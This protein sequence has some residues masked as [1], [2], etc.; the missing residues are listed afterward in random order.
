MATSL[1][2]Q[3]KGAWEKPAVL[4]ATQAK[5]VAALREGRL[6]SRPLPLSSEMPRDSAGRMTY[7]Q[8]LPPLPIP[9]VSAGGEG[10]TYH[11]EAVEFLPISEEDAQRGQLAAAKMGNLVALPTVRVSERDSLMRYRLPIE[12]A[13]PALGIIGIAHAMGNPFPCDAEFGRVP[14]RSKFGGYYIELL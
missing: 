12:M 4:A 1:E 13:E 9:E 8:A 5:M 7:W 11:V 6:I 14:G 2:A 3:M 10:R